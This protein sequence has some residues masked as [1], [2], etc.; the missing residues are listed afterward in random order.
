M[1]FYY[2]GI[3]VRTSKNHEYKYALIN[4]LEK[5]IIAVITCSSTYD[6]C[7]KE[8]NRIISNKYENIENY[9]RILK[10]IESG[11]DYYYCKMGR[12]EA[13]EKI[14]YSKE[15]YEHDLEVYENEVNEIKNNYKIV[16]LEQR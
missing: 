3:L 7:Q 15:Q 1:K 12:Y 11:K 13:K 2:N 5:G 9:K 14:R 4:Q 16:E 6:G 10:S 8:L